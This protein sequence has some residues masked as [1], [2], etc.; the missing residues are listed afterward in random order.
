MWILWKASDLFDYP[1]KMAASQIN[2]SK[3]GQKTLPQILSQQDILLNENTKTQQ[4]KT[5]WNPDVLWHLTSSLRN[6]FNLSGN[7]IIQ[8]I[9]IINK[10]VGFCLDQQS[11][12][13]SG[14][15][16]EPKSFGNQAV[17]LAFR[18]E[19]DRVQKN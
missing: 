17:V 6:P 2:T 10:D 7:L 9:I 11:S 14:Q 15:L 5:S 19:I 3:V 12:L 13:L 16:D 18:K 4:T 1:F 8:T